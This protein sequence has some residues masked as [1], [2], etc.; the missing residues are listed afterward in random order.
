MGHFRQKWIRTPAELRPRRLTVVPEAVDGEWIVSWV[1][2]LHELHGVSL[3]RAWDLVG[4][5]GTHRLPVFGYHVD[6]LDSDMVKFCAATGFDRATVQGMLLRQ[7]DGTALDFGRLNLHEKSTAGSQQLSKVQWLSSWVAGCPPCLRES[8]GVWRV[9]WRI[10]CAVVCLRHRVYLVNTCPR[11]SGRLRPS[12][13]SMKVSCRALPRGQ[14]GGPRKLCRF[15]LVQAEAVP[16]ADERMLRL[17][18]LVEVHAFAQGDAAR[19]AARVWFNTTRDMARV[20]FAGGAEHLLAGADAVVVDRF[21]AWV[22][23]RHEYLGR[24]RE[25]RR[26]GGIHAA[27]LLQGAPDTLLTAALMRAALAYV[28]PV[29]YPS[30]LHGMPS[31]PWP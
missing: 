26:T 23:V 27:Q 17:Q 3:T 13:P 21:A 19:A 31:Q 30:P 10:P 24:P 4:L 15:P 6:L 29:G 22:R 1:L 16:V 7:F 28:K 20:M 5:A 9:A 8:G 25:E 12:T 11:C 18:E 2:R 14:V